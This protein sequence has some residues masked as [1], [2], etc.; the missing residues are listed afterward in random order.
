MTE[1]NHATATEVPE[2]EEAPARVS[3]PSLP[4]E[5]PEAASRGPGAPGPAAQSSV[6]QG[7]AATDPAI[8]SLLE[9]LGAL[10]G[11]AVSAHGE[12]Y[13]GLHDD[14]MDALNEDIANQ[15][16]ATGDAAS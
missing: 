9:R 7:P 5:L 10:P 15:R 16:N 12:V 3:W 13:T 4:S 1:P 11:M 8:S 14:L 6:R 2:T